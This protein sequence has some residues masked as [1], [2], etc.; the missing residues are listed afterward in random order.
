MPKRILL[1]LDLRKKYEK[2][3]SAEDSLT[4]YEYELFKILPQLITGAMMKTELS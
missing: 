3:I 2:M 4:T 1:A